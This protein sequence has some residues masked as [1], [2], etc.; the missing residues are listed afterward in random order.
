MIPN[1]SKQPFS[2]SKRIKSFSYAFQGIKT[3]IKEEH[4]ARIHLVA[5]NI[6]VCLG[7]IFDITSIEWAILIICIAL[8]I[9]LEAINSGIENLADFCTKEQN[10]LIKKSKDISSGAVLISAIAS[11]IVASLIFLPKIQALF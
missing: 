1:K 5:T 6:V 8:V 3:L 4:N 2:I 9:S 7:F 11:I 10:Q